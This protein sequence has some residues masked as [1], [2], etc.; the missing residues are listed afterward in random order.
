MTALDTA[1]T[2]AMEATDRSQPADAS[3]V[4]LL[5]LAQNRPPMYVNWE[6]VSLQH[7]VNRYI[8]TRQRSVNRENRKTVQEAMG[9]Y[10][11]NFPA[12]C[13]DVEVFLDAVLHIGTER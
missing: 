2:V 13:E 6:A 4:R 11:G 3:R 9:R 5:D 8:R 1:A 7:F 12:R 10:R